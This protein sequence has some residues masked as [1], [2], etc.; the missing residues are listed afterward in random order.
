M[1]VGI[2]LVG[3]CNPLYICYRF[4]S[5]GWSPYP[6]WSADSVIVALCSYILQLLQTCF[7]FFNFP[8]YPMHLCGREILQFTMRSK[9]SPRVKLIGV[10]DIL[11]KKFISRKFHCKD[12]SLKGERISQFPRNATAFNLRRNQ[13]RSLF[14]CLLCL[15]S[16]VCCIV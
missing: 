15:K 8:L 2:I 5:Q 4:Q 7:K 11:L 6:N 12:V 13:D 10:G 14:N 16:G 1:L 9:N 3:E